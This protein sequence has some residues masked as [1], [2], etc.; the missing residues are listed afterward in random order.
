MEKLLESD[1]GVTVLLAGL[2]IVLCFHLLLR[3][4]SFLYEIFRKKT[5]SSERNVENLTTALRITSEGLSKLETRMT[6]IERDLNEVLK[7]K[8]DFRRLFTAVKAIAG[9]RWPE[10]RKNIVDEDF[11][12]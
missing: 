5:E 9:D 4:G 11:P 1:K 2:V 7:F 12:S 10:I 6:V 8:Q 3:F